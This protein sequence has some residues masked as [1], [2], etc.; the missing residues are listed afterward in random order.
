MLFHFV[1]PL[2]G[3]STVHAGMVSGFCD[4]SVYEELDRLGIDPEQCYLTPA[5][6]GAMS[7]P[8][9]VCT[10][11][12]GLGNKEKTNSLAFTRAGIDA[13][14]MDDSELMEVVADFLWNSDSRPWLEFDSFRAL[15]STKPKH[16]I[17]ATE[18]ATT[19]QP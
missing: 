14:T 15:C 7:Y 5:T 8:I 6:F 1:M 2:S 13:D 18:I 12:F 10:G 9:C 11:K 16:N 4:S 17:K 19:P 3:S